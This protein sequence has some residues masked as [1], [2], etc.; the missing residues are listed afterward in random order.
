[1]HMSGV[2]ELETSA[3]HQLSNVGMLIPHM[4]AVQDGPERPPP[5]SMLHSFTHITCRVL[6]IIKRTLAA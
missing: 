4:R 2:Q 3:A 5:Q 6:S 1:M